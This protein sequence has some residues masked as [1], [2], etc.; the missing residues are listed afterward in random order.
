MTTGILKYLP[1]ELAEK[2]RQCSA[3]ERAEELRIRAD[4]PVMFYAGSEH[5]VNYIPDK[6]V[7][8]RIV[9]A[10]SEHSMAAFFDEL[11]QGYFTVERGVRVG[12]AGRVVS[13]RGAV[14][15]IRDY[16]SVNI[17]FPRQM[18]GIHAGI[19]PYLEQQGR[20]RSTLIVSAPQHG[21]T[22][23]LRDIVRAV[24]KGE[25]YVPEKCVVV[26]ERNEV[27][28]GGFFDLGAR[29]DV[30]MACPKAEGMLMALRSLSPEVV[31]TDEIGSKADLDALYEAAN[32]GVCVLATA[33]AKNFAELNS[34]LFFR[35][36]LEKRVVERIVLLSQSKGRGTVQSIC[37]ADGTVLL[38]SPILLKAGG[39]LP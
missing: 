19:F 2:L 24:S 6:T 39:C 37:R 3:Y 11:R 18:I 8:R 23:L 27:S 33:H 30:L 13:E 22:T 5:V 38:E 4:Q 25:Q 21:K 20:L 34:R 1:M 10:I 15:M 31:A 29:T 9:L 16:T 12:V 26:D 28:G 35:E 14:K 17:R 36:L 32:S 7:V